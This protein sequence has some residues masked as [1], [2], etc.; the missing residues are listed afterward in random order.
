MDISN[1]TPEEKLALLKQLRGEL[2]PKLIATSPEIQEL[3][4]RITEIGKAN[5]IPSSTVIRLIVKGFKV[6]ELKDKG[7]IPELATVVPPPK[8]MGKPTT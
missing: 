5:N 4:V 3:M 1:L 8:K 6:Q 7:V 2:K